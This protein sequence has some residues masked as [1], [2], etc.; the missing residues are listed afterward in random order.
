MNKPSGPAGGAPPAPDETAP[1]AAASGTTSGTAWSGESTL[2]DFALLAPGERVE[3]ALTAGPWTVLRKLKT[4]EAPEAAE[5]VMAGDLRRL[6]VPDVLSLVHSTGLEGELTFVFDDATKRIAVRGGNVVF[7]SSTLTD[8]RLGEL[9]L[10]KGRITRE[11]FDDASQECTRDRRKL[12][13]VLLDRNIL[14]AH[15]LYLAVT[16]QVESILLSLFTYQSG[17]FAFAVR[18][19]RIATPVRLPFGMSHYILEGVRLSDELRDALSQVSDR[20]AVFKPSGRE[21]L[22]VADGRP[23]VERDVAA[24]L[25]GISAVWEV[26]AR[27]TWSEANTLLALARLLRA[28]L[29]ERVAPAVAEA[30]AASP[31]DDGASITALVESVNGFLR[32]AHRSLGASGADPAA[33]AGFFDSMKPHLRG[34]FAGI[35]LAEDASL[36]AARVVQNAERLPGTP[37]E[38]KQLVRAGLQEVVEFALWV[39]SDQVPAKDAERLD[40]TARRVRGGGSAG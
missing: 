7:A 11:V 28:R 37:S 26:L 24:L 18:P 23:G 40:A 39:A 38:R 3:V 25:D 33:L 36:D 22:A 9:L 16:E 14:S 1:A 27:S 17:S 6:A 8:D 29:I 5:V 21:A 12:G 10:A 20:L 31:Q 32:D 2:R 13:R 34:L 19:L 35:R 30:Q 4:D 15:D